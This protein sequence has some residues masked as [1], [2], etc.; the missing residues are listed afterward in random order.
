[1]DE[2]F[3]RNPPETQPH[4]NRFFLIEGGIIVKRGGHAQASIS[5]CRMPMPEKKMGAQRA[6]KI[7]KGG[8]KNTE[9]AATLRLLSFLSNLGATSKAAFHQG[10]MCVATVAQPVS[11]RTVVMGHASVSHALI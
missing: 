8:V 5:S 9:L 4:I 2:C 6:P 11:K 1:M 10:L 7:T 3:T